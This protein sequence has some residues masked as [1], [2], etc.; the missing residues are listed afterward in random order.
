MDCGE[1]VGE[2]EY[3]IDEGSHHGGD[4]VSDEGIAEVDGAEWNEGRSLEDGFVES[5]ARFTGY[6]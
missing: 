4:A 3:D 5:M 6:L 1:V 2:G